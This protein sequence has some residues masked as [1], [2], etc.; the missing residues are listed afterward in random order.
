MY[1][2]RKTKKVSVNHV[3]L[4]CSAFISPPGK[5]VMIVIEYM[6]NGSLDEFLRVST[7]FRANKKAD[8]T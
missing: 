5:P 2:W 3:S 8:I 4:Y 6:E 1:F 7:N